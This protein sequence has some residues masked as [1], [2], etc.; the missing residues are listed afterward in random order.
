MPMARNIWRNPKHLLT[1]QLWL[2]QRSVRKTL[3]K[4][5]KR[6]SKASGEANSAQAVVKTRAAIRRQPPLPRDAL[7]LAA[8]L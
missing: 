6:F 7:A 1:L 2:G 3:P 4:I 8:S 5:Y